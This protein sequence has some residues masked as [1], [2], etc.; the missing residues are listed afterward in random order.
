MIA[1]V[2]LNPLDGHK[3]VV[4]GVATKRILGAYRGKR[5]GT[6]PTCNAITPGNANCGVT[7]NALSLD[8]RMMNEL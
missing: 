4:E 2:S 1:S 6:K 3:F 5:T 7:Q 8:K